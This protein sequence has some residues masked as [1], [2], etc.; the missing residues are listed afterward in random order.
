[1]SN[2]KPMHPE[3]RSLNYTEILNPDGT[4]AAYH[5]RVTPRQR[6]RYRHKLRRQLGTFLAGD[7]HYP[8]DPVRPADYPAKR[9]TR[10]GGGRPRL[11]PRK[12]AQ[13]ERWHGEPG[14]YREFLRRLRRTA[15]KGRPTP[16]QR[17]RAPRA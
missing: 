4:T 16:R 5:Q 12:V 15:T 3:A 13:A 11:L 14:T 9:Y 2:A 7:G 1:M 10:S 17:K 6:R 8:G